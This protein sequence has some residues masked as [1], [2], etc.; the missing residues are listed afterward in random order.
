[1]AILICQWYGRLTQPANGGPGP[2]LGSGELVDKGCHA[3]GLE[4]IDAAQSCCDYQ[5]AGGLWRR[6]SNQETT[7]T[8]NDSVAGAVG[9]SVEF[10]PGFV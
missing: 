2:L 6:E 10:E 9:H 5:S 7:E 8:G 1:V 4:H 3:L